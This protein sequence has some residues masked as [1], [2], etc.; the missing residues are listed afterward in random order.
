[1]YG[2][3]DISFSISTTRHE[4]ILHTTLSMD[5]SPVCF[6]SP[7]PVSQSVCF[8]QNVTYEFFWYISAIQ[9]FP[10]YRTLSYERILVIISRTLMATFRRVRK[11]AKIDYWFRH[12]CLS[13]RMEQL[14][15]LAAF[16]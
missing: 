12:V 6:V 8:Y 3:G 16:S 14:G 1:M 10:A 4:C 11:I 15:S 13:V 7:S 9:K 5:H 2:N